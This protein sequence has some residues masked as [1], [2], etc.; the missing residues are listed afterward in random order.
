MTDEE[1]KDLQK[2]YPGLPDWDL[3]RMLEAMTFKGLKPTPQQTAYYFGYLI[4]LVS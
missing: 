2:I 1:R 3:D 4:G